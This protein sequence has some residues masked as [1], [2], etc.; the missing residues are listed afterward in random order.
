MGAY[1]FDH[2]YLGDFAG[3]CDVDL[4][5]FAVL[6]ASWLSDDAGLDVAPYPLGDGVVDLGELLVLAENWLSTL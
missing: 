1:E 6:G 2:R 5:D 3:G 4:L